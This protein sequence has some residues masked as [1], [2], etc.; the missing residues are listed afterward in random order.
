MFIG[1]IE[2]MG[3]IMVVVFLGD[4]WC[5]IVCV[6]WVVVDVVYGEFIVVFGVCLMVVGLMVDIFDVDVIRQM[7][8]VLVIGFVM[9]G[10]RVNIEKVMFVGVWLGGY[11][12]QGYVDGIGDVF[13]VC[14]GVQWSVLCI[15]FFVDFVFLVVDKGLI[16]VDGIFLM[17]SVVSFLISL[18][19]QDGY[20]FEVFLILEIFVV[21][22][23]GFCVVGDCVNLEMDIFVCYVEWL[24]VFCVVLE[25]GL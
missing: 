10:I 18:G 13:E 9:I 15:S 3:E 11:I 5:F 7:F 22:M 19:I 16:L 24:F 17:V 8:D 6:L 2:E 21:I 25:G 12:V 23:L 14:F 1:I 20:W 4:G